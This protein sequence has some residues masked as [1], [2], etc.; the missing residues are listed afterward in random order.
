MLPFK[1]LS[2]HQN[3]LV[4]TRRVKVLTMNVDLKKGRVGVAIVFYDELRTCVP[5]VG[6]QRQVRSGGAGRQVTVNHCAQ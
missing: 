5:M 4:S 1:C 2:Q 3:G 6:P